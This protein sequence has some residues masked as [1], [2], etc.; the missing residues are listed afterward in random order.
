M[1]ALDGAWVVITRPAHQADTLARLVE[2]EGGHV[3]RFPVLEIQDPEDITPLIE[4]IDRLDTFDIAV[5]ISPNAVA[6]AMN[7]IQAR[8][9]LPAE[10]KIAAIG[11]GS[12][13][14]LHR[15]GVKPDLVPGGRFNSEALLEMAAM[16]NVKNKWIVIFRGEGGR[17]LLGDTLIHR[18]AHVEYAECYRRTR[19]ATDN[20]ALMRH[21]AHGEVDVIVVTSMAGLRNLFDLVGGAGRHRLTETPLVVVSERM[22]TACRELGCTVNPIV[23]DEPSD[24]GLL[25]AIKAWRAASRSANT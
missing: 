15:F 12:A 4:L 5:F 13:K 22:V 24:I 18:G 11:G 3:I 16:Q 2:A 1:P 14:T 21:W 19:P 25:N 17:E 9:T 23:A 7:L 8:R 20:T 10:L 6:K